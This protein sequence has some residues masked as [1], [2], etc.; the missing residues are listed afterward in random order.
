[1]LH[2]TLTVAGTAAGP[3]RVRIELVRGAGRRPAATFSLTVAGA[4]RRTVR[5]P[6]RLL[7]GRLSL[8][9][10]AAGFGVT[11][12]P[13]ARTIAIARPRAG[14]VDA[15]TASTSR[16]GPAATS[17]RGNFHE[18]WARFH[19]AVRPASGQRITIT[20]FP[21][22]SRVGQRVERP[23]QAVVESFVRSTAPLAK[24]RWRS[25]LRAGATIVA[26][27]AIRVE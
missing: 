18:L 10:A 14:I 19:F 15:A 22:G 16:R 17:V 9:V 4:F 2:G 11:V 13:R 25:I 1:V 3:A 8:S 27:V 12:A 24:G 6:A 26:Q 21:P 5:L 7:P 23:G 20:W